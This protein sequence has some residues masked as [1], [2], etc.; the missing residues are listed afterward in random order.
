ML[1]EPLS[2]CCLSGFQLI[3]SAHAGNF[4]NRAAPSAASAAAAAASTPP[5]A[6]A[7]AAAAPS[8]PP[9]PPVKRIHAMD[10]ISSKFNRDSLIHIGSL[11]L[12]FN[13]TQKGYSLNTVRGVEKDG[14]RLRES[15]GGG[16][17]AQ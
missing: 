4:G 5:A 10:D 13:H 17:S 2:V 15:S 8:A 1:P 7:A 6:A 16:G 9:R 3:M 11:M 12:T 14:V